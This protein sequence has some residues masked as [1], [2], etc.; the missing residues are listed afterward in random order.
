[1]FSQQYSFAIAGLKSGLGRRVTVSL[2]T[3]LATGGAV[4]ALPVLVAVGAVWKTR[5]DVREL[6]A[7]HR[8]LEIEAANYRAALEALTR[9]IESQQSASPDVR[10]ASA[11]PSASTR[12]QQISARRGR[13]ESP[14][15]APPAV[16]RGN[17]EAAGQPEFAEALAR[18]G[19]IEARLEAASQEHAHLADPP[20][21]LPR[22]AEMREAEPVSPLG[23]PRQPAI[24]VTPSSDI[25]LAVQHVIAE[26]LSGLENRSLVALKRV[27]PSL[28]GSHERAIQTEFENARSVRASF[29]GPQITVKGDTTTVTGLRTYNLLTQD[30]Q[31]LSSVT[32]TT[33]TLRRSG[34]EWL[35]EHV[36]H[37]PA[38]RDGGPGPAPIP[39]DAF[40]PW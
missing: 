22:V 7:S 17:A 23:E 15:P 28:G 12:V 29:I 9:Q 31:H 8:A 30:G 1:M 27:W 35:I 13:D 5:S 24:S 16:R 20:T 33:M 40:S 11:E 10:A 2:A 18:L 37:R 38:S 25:E 32:K 19:Q 36:E 3:V 39:H 4:I 21:S 26:Y 6:A 14:R 34:G